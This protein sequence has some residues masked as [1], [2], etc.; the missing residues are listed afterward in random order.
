MDCDARLWAQQAAALMRQ[1][2]YI[3]TVGGDMS[4]NK[5]ELMVNGLRLNAT[6]RIKTFKWSVGYEG[7]RGRAILSAKR[8]ARR[9]SGSSSCPTSSHE[10]DQIDV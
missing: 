2:A 1:D 3:A 10:S 4:R 7:K 8:R 9:R 6:P 5:S